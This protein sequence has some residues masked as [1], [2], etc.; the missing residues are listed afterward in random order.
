MKLTSDGKKTGNA[1]NFQDSGGKW[2]QYFPGN[3]VKLHTSN[4]Y[5]VLIKYVGM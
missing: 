2:Y 5:L 1:H 3:K 4:S